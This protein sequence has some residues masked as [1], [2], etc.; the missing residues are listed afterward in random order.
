M[1]GAIG[2]IIDASVLQIAVQQLGLDPYS[3]RVLSYLVAATG[4]WSLNRRFTFGRS[5]S[6]WHEEWIRYVSVN[7]VGAGVNYAVYAFCVW[8]DAF[9]REHLVWAVAAGSAI[10]LVINFTASRYLVFR[11]SR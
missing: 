4:T 10:A 7:G 2:F 5:T 9:F 6:R 1:V 8:Y 3:G 11:H